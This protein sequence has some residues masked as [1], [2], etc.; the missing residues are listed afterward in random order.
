MIKKTNIPHHGLML[1]TMYLDCSVA[2]RPVSEGFLLQRTAKQL[3]HF[4]QQRHVVLSPHF[5]ADG[6]VLQEHT[7]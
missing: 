5:A 7:G 2:Q 1:L 6:A 3:G 4:A